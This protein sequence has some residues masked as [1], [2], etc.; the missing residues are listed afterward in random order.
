MERIRSRMERI[1]LA[2]L[3]MVSAS[4]RKYES[5]SRFVTN[6]RAKPTGMCLQA[7]Q[8]KFSSFVWYHAGVSQEM[9]QFASSG[10]SCVGRLAKNIPVC[11]SHAEMSFGGR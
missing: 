3:E 6:A 8:V 4:L 10:V 1:S 9:V 2:P 7:T 11:L 5:Q